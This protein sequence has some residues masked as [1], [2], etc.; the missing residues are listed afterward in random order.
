MQKSRE[1]LILAGAVCL[2]VNIL[3]ARIRW[4]SILLEKSARLAEQ[5][6]SRFRMLRAIGMAARF[7]LGSE[8]H[9]FNACAVWVISIQAVFTVA[10]DLRAIEGSQALRAKLR[11]SNVNVFNAE[12]EVI[13]YPEFFVVSV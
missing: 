9:N 3:V 1:N 2:L 12:R 10:A 7:P 5:N 13:L 6:R 4:G 11:C 8:L